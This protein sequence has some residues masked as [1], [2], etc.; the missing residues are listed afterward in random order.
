MWRD[1]TNSGRPKED[2]QW[3]ADGMTLG[4]LI[5]TADGLCDRK[6]AADLLGVG[7]IIFC[8]ATGQRITGSFWGKSPLQA[9]SE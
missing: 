7:W 3:V 2:M 8:R 1:I 6:Q 9:H 4:T 5:W